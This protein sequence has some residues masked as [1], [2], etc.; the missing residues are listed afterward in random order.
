MRATQTNVGHC[1]NAVTERKRE[2]EARIP[3]ESEWKGNANIGT[4]RNLR[5]PFAVDAA[6]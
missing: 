2:R 3:L 4:Q 6:L 5:N 1:K